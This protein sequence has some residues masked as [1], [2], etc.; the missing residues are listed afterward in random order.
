[1]SWKGTFTGHELYLK[2]EKGSERQRAGNRPSQV[3]FTPSI[4][5]IPAAA[6]EMK[7]RRE[8]VVLKGGMGRW[9]NKRKP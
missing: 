4:G 6:A 1:M 9:K 5:S 8:R 2:G 3:R 7:P